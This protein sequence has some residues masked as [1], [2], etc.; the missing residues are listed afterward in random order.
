MKLFDLRSKFHQ[1]P[2]TRV[3]NTQERV[4]YSPLTGPS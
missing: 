2:G 1:T 4:T 3:G